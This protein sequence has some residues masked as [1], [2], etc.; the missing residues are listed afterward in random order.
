MDLFEQYF[1]NI[2]PENMREGIQKL[3]TASRV[4]RYE[5]DYITE[6]MLSDKIG[7]TKLA[8]LEQNINKLLARLADYQQAIRM[9]RKYHRILNH[10]D[11]D[12]VVRPI[13]KDPYGKTVEMEL[14]WERSN[15]K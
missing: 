14:V 11:G 9:S 7:D 13:N 6:L 2:S 5:I 15:G 4:I 1:L 8:E 10:M 3:L 12:V